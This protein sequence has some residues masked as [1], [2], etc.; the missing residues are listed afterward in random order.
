[1]SSA[2]YLVLVVVFVQIISSQEDTRE[3][4]VS[5][6]IDLQWNL[7]THSESIVRYNSKC[8]ISVLR[9]YCL[10][11]AANFSSLGK[12]IEGCF[13]TD[14]YS[15]YRN[16]GVYGSFNVSQCAP[17][18]R[19]GTLCGECIPGHGP[20]PYSFSLRCMKCPKTGLWSRLLYYLLI[21]YGPLTLFMVVIVVF[22]I[23]SNSAPMHGFIFVCQILSCS[24]IMRCFTRMGELGHIDPYTYKI[25]GTAYGIWNLDFFRPVYEPFCLHESLKTLHVISLD[26]LIAAYPLVTIIVLYILVNMYSQNYRLVVWAFQPFH[27]CCLRFRQKLKITTSLIDAFGTFFSLSFV[28]M[29]STV[30]DL[31]TSSLVWRDD[32]SRPSVH[33]YYQGGTVYF[34]NDHLPFALLGLFLLLIFNVL[35]IAGLLIYSFPR[36]QWLLRCLPSSVQNGLYPFMDNILSCYKDGTNGTRNCRYFAIIYQ[37]SRVAIFL[38]MLWTTS[39]LTYPLIAFVVSLTILLVALIQPYKVPLYN[40]LDTFLLLCLCSAMLGDIAFFISYVNDPEH[41]TVCLV[42]VIFSVS[43]PFLYATCFIGYKVC[44]LLLKKTRIAHKIIIE[45]F[46]SKIELSE[47]SLLL[48]Q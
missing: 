45:V 12:C 10:T 28:K 39:I 40:T 26:L 19:H 29:F 9:C 18:N 2:G 11:A 42:L 15:E 14:K 32:G 38:I 21:A 23:S 44:V 41:A 34:S 3:T 8:E 5:S 37:I 43:T 4:D 35:P 48:T 36:T 22:T 6:C 20:A 17:Y 1:M 31:M 24:N 46:T 33:I 13:I 30:T 47:S 25:I 7:P 16:L 27:R